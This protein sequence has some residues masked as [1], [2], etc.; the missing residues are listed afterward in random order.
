MKFRKKALA[1]LVALPLLSSSILLTS[2]GEDSKEKETEKFTITWSVDSN[3]TVS[4][5][6]Y[7]EAP[8]EVEDGTSVVFSLTPKTG[9]EISSV[10]A[11]NK[12]VSAKN[13]KYTVSVTTN[14]TIV[15]EASEKVSALEVTTK[16]TK[17]KYFAGD[18]VDTTGMEVK[19][20]YETGRSETL[21][22]GDSGYSISPSVFEG[23]ETSFKVIYGEK[24]V[25]VALDSKVE[26]L[27]TIDPNGGEI[28]SEWVSGIASRNL[29]NYSY[30]DGV[31]QF[32]FYNDLDSTIT[33]PTSEE[34]T[35]TDYKFL[36]WTDSLTS[37]AN[38]TV[39]SSLNIKANWEAELV[40]LTSCEL[41]VED[42]TPYL[43]IKGKFKAA[44]EVYLFLY[45]GN[46]KVS[47]TGDTYTGKRGDDLNVK[48]D[49]TKLKDG[50]TEDGESFKGKWM[51]IRFNAKLG[52][53]EET[54]ELYTTDT[55]LTCD[56]TSK[57]TIG[58]F[59][60]LFAQYDKK[61]KVYFTENEV[62]YTLDFSQETSGDTTVDYL[63]ISGSVSEKY[64][65]CYARTTFY[66]SS[67]GNAGEGLIASD[68]TFAIKYDLSEFAAEILSYCHFEI[69][70]KG[71]DGTETSKYGGTSTNLP[72]SGYEGTFPALENSPNSTL[73]NAITYKAS[74]GFRYYLGYGWDG[75]IL[76]AVNE[77]V[78][79]TYDSVNLELK[80]D[81]V[82]YVVNGTYTGDTSLIKFLFNFQHNSNVDGLGW[83]YLYLTET[84][85]ETEVEMGVSGNELVPTFD[86]ENNTYKLYIDPTSLGFKDSGDSKWCLTPHIGLSSCGDLKPSSIGSES[87][88][89]NGVKYSLQMDSNTW[90]TASLVMETTDGEDSD[91]NKSYTVGD[92]DIEEVDGKAIFSVNGTYS[93][94]TQS[95]LEGLNHVLSI[96]KNPLRMNDGLND[97]SAASTTSTLTANSDGTW[98][99]TCD[100][101]DLDVYCYMVKF[102]INTTTKADYKLDEDYSKNI[103]V[104]TKKY[105]VTCTAGSSNSGENW[106]L[107]GIDV[108]TVS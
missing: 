84:V 42:E 66:A 95:E 13:G 39:T 77:N 52:D 93:G 45:E 11:N 57:I 8:T 76:Y 102:A 24:E 107:V 12:R 54:M 105:S 3:L 60:Y 21:T 18:S 43:V 9:Y 73:T 79:V 37:V 4:V 75:L 29:N 7:D 86:E 88:I 97:W 28:S 91:P 33:L 1:L 100:I 101:T 67:E 15:C 48:F 72:T 64:A 25:E 68:G 44:E 69:Y 10:K 14:T 30:E 51:D 47:F 49:L 74:S 2:C 80:D 106:G 58:R 6:G 5:D 59:T 70:E 83:N 27:I 65:G 82:Y 62:L 104:G 31:V 63:T 40:E 16:P 85:D 41:V 108:T 36:N 94:Y 87:Y 99:V 26:Y 61:I 35:R 22:Y 17:L 98:K 50:K 71:E 90:N 89:K 78:S 19:V 20:S 92:P 32:S 55:N 46:A 38:F 103:T 53:Q 96:E 23:G 56:L 34:I 81:K